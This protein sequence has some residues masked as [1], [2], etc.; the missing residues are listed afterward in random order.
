MGFR[1][2]TEK[3]NLEENLSWNRPASFSQDSAYEC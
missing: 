1:K 3:E 2:G